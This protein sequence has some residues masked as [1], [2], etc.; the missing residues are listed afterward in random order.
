MS[1]RTWFYLI[2]TG[3]CISMFAGMLSMK[4][5]VA[6]LVRQ[7]QALFQQQLQLKED[8]RVLQAEYAHLTSPTR[9]QSLAKHLKLKP[10]NVSQILPW[11]LQVHP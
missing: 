5:H 3:I 1:T 6:T 7:R 8:L 11:Q 9:L 10:V 4:A 2:L